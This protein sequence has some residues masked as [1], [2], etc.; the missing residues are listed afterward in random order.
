MLKT[1]FYKLIF[2]VLISF[3]VAVFS[4]NRS[5]QTKDFNDTSLYA[6]HYDCLAS[7]QGIES[8]DSIISA[9]KPEFVY[10][11]FAYLCSNFIDFYFFK[12]VF[13][14]SVSFGVVWSVLI[15]SPSIILPV[16][17]LLADFRFWEYVANVLRHGLAASVFLVGFTVYIR[18]RKTLAFYFRY[19]AMGTHLGSVF[20]FFAPIR[21]MSRYVLI[22]AIIFAVILVNTSQH[23]LPFI[24]DTGFSGNK[25]AYY[26]F[27]NIA[28]DFSLPLHYSLIG[29]IGFF[30]YRK[31]A[32]SGYIASYNILIVLFSGSL[33]L[34]LIGLSYRA[35]SF[36]LPFVVICA[37]HQIRYL[38]LKFKSNSNCAYFLLSFIYLILFVLAFIR[39]YDAFLV[40]LS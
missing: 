7:G 33:L 34:A 29:I 19:L 30:L 36:M 22:S 10:Q 14:F 3:Y 27:A 18:Y 26:V 13:A 38:S 25:L 32:D 6:M 39:N 1:N 20:L 12:I 31:I 15:L 23:W 37:S 24:M 8:C 21:R 4:A 9:S 40:H 5:D 11:Y 28:Y 35:I 2:A 17:M 16:I